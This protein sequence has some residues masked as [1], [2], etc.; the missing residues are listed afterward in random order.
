MNLNIK[1]FKRN[2]YHKL[3]GGLIRHKGRL[4]TER[5]TRILVNIAIE[6]GYET[7]AD[8]PDD[9][10]NKIC[11]ENTSYKE[12]EKYDDTPIFVSLSEFERI[13]KR[14]VNYHYYDFDPETL[15]QDIRYELGYEED[16]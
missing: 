2:C 11:D 13:I 4:M 12:Y 15:I 3:M 14:V 1:G 10:A 6:K 9:L 7:L 5:E 8:I 16:D